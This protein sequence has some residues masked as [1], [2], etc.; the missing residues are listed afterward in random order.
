MVITQI[1]G[2][3]FESYLPTDIQL[4]IYKQ[5]INHHNT[6]PLHQVLHNKRKDMY[7]NQLIY[8]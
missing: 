2:Y 7:N 6:I 4:R 3:H 5:N 1:K 8:S